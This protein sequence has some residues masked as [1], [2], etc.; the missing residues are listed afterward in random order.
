[1]TCARKGCDVILCRTYVP[2]I[3]HV[4]RECQ[5]EFKNY[6]YSQKDVIADSHGSITRALKNFMETQKCDFHNSNEVDV[7]GFFRQYTPD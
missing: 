4:C 7:E 3:G 1:M 2:S 6:L 5:E